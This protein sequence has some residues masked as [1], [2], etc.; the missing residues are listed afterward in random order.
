MNMARHTG[1]SFLETLRDMDLAEE[2]GM[3]CTKSDGTVEIF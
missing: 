2:L 1:K 3:L